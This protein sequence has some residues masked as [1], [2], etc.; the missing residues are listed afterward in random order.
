[1]NY[2][3][4]DRA[5]SSSPAAAADAD[6]DAVTLD[7]SIRR[8]ATVDALLSL[9]SEPIDFSRKTSRHTDHTPPPADNTAA[10][11]RSLSRATLRLSLI[12]I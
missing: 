7:L 11:S 8:D 1:M 9:Q 3:V 4:C 10:A 6:A 12:H 2:G 5:A